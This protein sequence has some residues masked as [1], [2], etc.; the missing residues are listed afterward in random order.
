MKVDACRMG[1]RISPVV[2]EKCGEHWLRSMHSV[3]VTQSVPKFGNQCAKVIGSGSMGLE[4]FVIG[5]RNSILF[6]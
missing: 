2:T 5:L 1:K 6:E 3:F 4:D